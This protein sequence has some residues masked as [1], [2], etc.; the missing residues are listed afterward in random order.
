MSS[1]NLNNFNDLINQANQ[2]ITCGPSCQQSQT[3]SQLKQNYLNAE[4]NMISAPQQ[5]FNAQ[6]EYITYTKGVSGYNEFMDKELQTKAD[7]IANTYQKK[8]DDEINVIKQKIQTYDGLSTNFNNLVDLYKKYK[9]ENHMLETKL[10]DK[11]SDILTNDRKTYYEDQGISTLNT[12]NYFLIGVYAFII[13]VFLLSIFLVKT[14]V[15]LSGRI[16]ILIL[17]VIYPFICY[18]FFHLLYKMYNRVKEYLPSN[19]YRNL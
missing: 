6:K 7:A 12:Y 15:K 17:M 14:S 3:S 1:F 16:F 5:L 18:G 8:I 2:L 13:I 4:T 19:A 10:K 11:S 9:K